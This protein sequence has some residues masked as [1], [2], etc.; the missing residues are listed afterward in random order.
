LDGDLLT[1]VEDTGVVADL[2]GDRS[3]GGEVNV[4]GHIPSCLKSGQV[5]EG[6]SAGLATG[7]DG[8]EVGR[9]S[10]RNGEPGRLALHERG[11][12]RDRGLV[13]LSRDQAS[14][15]GEDGGRSAVLHGVIWKK[16]KTTKK[17][18]GRRRCIELCR[19]R[20]GRGGWL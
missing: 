3:A 13:L 8:Q 16:T 20:G 15:G 11:G 6:S 1:V 10:A 2:E 19:G 14:D 18:V 9:S 4:P 17:K 7:D 12:S 5:L